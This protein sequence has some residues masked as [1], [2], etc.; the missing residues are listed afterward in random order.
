MLFMI[1]QKLHFCEKYDSVLWYSFSSAQNAL[2]QSE[3]SSL[4]SITS[5]GGVNIYLRILHRDNHKGKVESETTF[6]G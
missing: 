1:L 2:N 6:F 4:W 3:C 5:L